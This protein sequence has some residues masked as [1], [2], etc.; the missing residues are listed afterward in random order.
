MIAKMYRRHLT[1]LKLGIVF[2][3]G[4]QAVCQSSLHHCCRHLS[5]HPR[6]SIRQLPPVNFS[7]NLITALCSSR[8]LLY[9]V[10]PTRG[11]V[12]QRTLLTKGKGA[13]DSAKGR[14]GKWRKVLA[15]LLLGTTGAGGVYYLLQNEQEKRKIRVFFGGVHRFVRYCQI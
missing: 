8:T 12:I 14:R 15:G 4:K 6:A 13:A 7:R 11:A 10:V 1:T 2:P 5:K 9:R 3:L